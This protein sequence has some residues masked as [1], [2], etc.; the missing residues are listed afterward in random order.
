MAT[1]TLDELIDTIE[2]ALSTAASLKRSQ[3][4][5]ELSEGIPGD[6]PLLQVY[7]E[8]NTGTDAI[9]ATDRQT[10]SGKHSIKEYLIHA[11]LYAQQRRHIGEDMRS[12]VTAIN[13]LEDILDTRTYDLFGLS[14]VM[15]F[16]WHWRRVTFVYGAVEYVGAR[17]F[18][19]VRTG[20]DT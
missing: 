5:D 12:L 17:F 9:T 1:Y 10:L 8:E 14:Y 18:L 4:Y 3:T 6:C 11:D 19:T 13:E 16:R 15:S 20:S 2:A 7:P